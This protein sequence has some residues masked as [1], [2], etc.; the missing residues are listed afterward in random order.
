ML[1]EKIKIRRMKQYE[2]SIALKWAKLE[3]WNPGLN[4]AELFYKADPNGFFCG[5]VEGH[6]EG[7]IVAVGSAV[8]YDSSFAFCGLYIVHPEFRDKGYGMALTKA[9]LFY[10]RGCNIG[11]DGVL[12]NVHLYENIGYKKYY[13]NARFQFTGALRDEMNASIL[14]INRVSFEQI[15][16]YDSQC[17]PA[18]RDNFLQAWINQDNSFSLVWLEDDQ[19]KGYVVCRECHEGFKI[20]PL[21]ADNLMIAEQLLMACEW[22]LDGKTLIIDMPEI[23]RD[24]K[25]LIDVF[26]MKQVFA[27]A[28][29]YNKELPELNYNKIFGVTSF[30]L[31]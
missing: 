12:E 22:G 1:T 21:Y 23:N 19:V 3:G 17:F 10:A 14:N 24:T 5:T 27:T 8:K 31:G 18:T 26:K 29:M 25:K 16:Q 28:R 11:I 6:V 20:A 30:E 4:D 9:R 15:K 2:V 13:E 7:H